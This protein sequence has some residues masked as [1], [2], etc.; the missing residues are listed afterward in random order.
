MLIDWFTVAAQMVN[1]L[2]LVWLLKRFLYGPIITAMQDRRDR[3]ADELNNARLARE[4]AD[5]QAE[6]LSKMRENLKLETQSMLTEAQTA[7]NERREFWLNEAKA[8][9]EARRRAWTKSIER[10][11]VAISEQLRIRMGEQIIRLSEKVLRDLA[12]ED[13]ES[14]VLDNFMAQLN[15]ADSAISLSDDVIVRTGFP[16]SQPILQ[17]LEISIREHF[18]GCKDISAAQDAS[19]GFGIVM[20]SGDNKWEW[21]LVS[22][23]DDVETTIFAELTETK[24]GAP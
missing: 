7:A 18:P 12:G 22:Y 8:E 3:L 2:I 17:R 5:R 23:L 4:K 9:V 14:R 10:E 6:D 19:L 21:N 15:N 24:A 1:F 20:V 13:L 11:Q 16:I